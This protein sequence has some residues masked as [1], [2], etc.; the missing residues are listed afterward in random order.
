MTALLHH[1]MHSPFLILSFLS[2][3]SSLLLS[4]PL[5]VVGEPLLMGGH[6]EPLEVGYWGVVDANIDWCERNYQVTPYL[7]E[8]W[9]ALS[10]LPIAAFAA[11]GYMAGRR[12]A[13]IETRFGLAFGLMALVGFGSFAFHA[14]LRRYAQALDELPM[15]YAAIALTYNSIDYQPSSARRKRLREN[16]MT[17]GHNGVSEDDPEWGLHGDDMEDDLP[18]RASS[19]PHGP[20]RN[21]VAQRIPLCPFS[22]P[23]CHRWVLKLV[24]VSV[25]VI[26]TAIYLYF[27]QFY[28]VF[29]IGY[30]TFLLSFVAIMAMHLWWSP[31]GKATDSYNDVRGE[32]EALGQSQVQG[33]QLEPLSAIVTSNNGH[34]TTTSSPSPDGSS[35]RSTPDGAVAALNDGAAE[36]EHKSTSHKSS[37]FV[38]GYNPA[39]RRLFWLGLFGYF[40]GFVFWMYENTYCT[41][42]PTGALGQFH[43]LWHILAGV[44]TF[45]IIQAQ[46]LWRA[47]ESGARNVEVKFRPH[48]STP[49][50]LPIVIV[51]Y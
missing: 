20:P 13:R 49:A 42:L 16:G 12:Y 34:S 3:L 18:I 22:R 6:E 2:F 17:N 37:T 44:G 10:S 24:L 33:M 47:E 26:L 1:S 32:Y 29:F 31:R 50:A 30:S 27:P 45:C 8:C 36:H 40:S 14:T 19:M 21:S 23:L 46:V 4:V 9:N 35:D 39:I 51:K 43:A 15:V 48:C 5:P 28:A 7:A 11:I 25:A 38:R 41:T